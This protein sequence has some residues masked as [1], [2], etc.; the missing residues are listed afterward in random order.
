VKKKY[1]RVHKLCPLT[2]TPARRGLRSSER[3]GPKK[4]ETHCDANCQ[5]ASR[6]LTNNAGS[7]SKGI[8]SQRE[9]GGRG[10]GGSGRREENAGVRRTVQNSGGG[11]ARGQRGEK[12]PLRKIEKVLTTLYIDWRGDQKVNTN[13]EQH[14]ANAA[15][16]F[17]FQNDGSHKSLSKT[18]K[19]VLFMC[20]GT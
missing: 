14:R 2:G 4:R 13:G 15:N 3:R 12:Y 16:F 20:K 18:A 5:R 9:W 7:K 8:R 6:D 11:P 19:I 1:C 17:K 10:G